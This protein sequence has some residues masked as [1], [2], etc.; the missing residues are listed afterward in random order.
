MSHAEPGLHAHFSQHLIGLAE[1]E[2]CACVRAGEFVLPVRLGNPKQ[3]LAPSV[4][5]SGSGGVDV[6]MWPKWLGMHA[7]PEW[8]LNL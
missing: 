1:A 8:Q 3:G 4:W 5:T 7:A 6:H 2:G